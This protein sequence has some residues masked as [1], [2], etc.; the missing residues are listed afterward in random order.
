MKHYII[1]A[2]A[3]KPATVTVI[4]AVR[5][6][7]GAAPYFAATTAPAAAHTTIGKVVPGDN[8]WPGP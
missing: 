6:G 3:A 1:A 4:A 2:R 5:L 8:P 7:A